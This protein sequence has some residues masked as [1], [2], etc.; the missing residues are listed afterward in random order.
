MKVEAKGCETRYDGQ[1]EKEGEARRKAPGPGLFIRYMKFCFKCGKDKP[2]NGFK[3]VRPGL[4]KCADC[5]SSKA[6][7]L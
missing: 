7:P 2:S 5:L 6:N 1:P 4:F 3:Q